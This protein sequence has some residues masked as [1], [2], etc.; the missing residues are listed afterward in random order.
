M[1][2]GLIEIII[3]DVALIVLAIL[4]VWWVFLRIWGRLAERRAKENDVTGK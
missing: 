1:F 3:L 2:L 4:V